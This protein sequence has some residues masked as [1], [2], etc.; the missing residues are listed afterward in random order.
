MLLARSV[1]LNANLLN[2]VRMQTKKLRGTG[3]EFLKVNPRQPL[4]TRLGGLHL[5]F[6]AVVPDVVHRPR[7]PVEFGG[8]LVPKTEFYGYKQSKSSLTLWKLSD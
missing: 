6:V 3:S 4:A 2:S 1:V 7:L 8:M 5:G